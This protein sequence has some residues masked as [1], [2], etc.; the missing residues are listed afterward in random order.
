VREIQIGDTRRNHIR[1]TTRLASGWISLATLVI[2]LGWCSAWPT[3]AQAQSPGN[4]TVYASST[5]QTGSAAFIDASVVPQQTDICYTLYKIISGATYAYPSTGAVIDA[6]GINSNLTCAPGNTPWQHTGSSPATAPSV[7]LLPAATIT[8]N[9][10]WTM[11]ANTHI[12]GEGPNLTILQATPGFSGDMIDMGAGNSTFCGTTQICQGVQVE[13][14]QVNGGGG[15]G[16]VNSYSQDASYVNDVML[17][18]LGGIGLSIGG[19]IGGSAMN[20]G[21]YSN[22]T[23][24]TGTLSAVCVQIKGVSGGTRGIRGLT[25]TGPSGY[26]KAAVLLDSSNNVI[27]DVRIVGFYDGIR[28]GSQ[29][30]AA[31]N[32]LFN[33]L[34][35]TNAKAMPPP[36]NVVHIASNGYTVSDL[37][38]MGVVNQGTGSYAIEDDVTVTTLPDSSLAMYVLGRKSPGGYYSRLTTSP[39]AATWAFGPNAPTGACVRGSLHSNDSTSNNGGTLYVC[40]FNTSGKLVWQVVL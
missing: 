7:I 11:P 36:V 33:I 15:N 13:H 20:S 22:L 1:S 23:C 19:S 17:L 18:D 31:S 21:P 9:T 4:N 34:G 29:A 37:S 38:I 3:P 14:L 26:S 24:D 30:A 16:I 25:C 5:A 10:T 39:N 35:D 28:I 40:D 32:A 27:K 2:L 8:I 12:V 6:R